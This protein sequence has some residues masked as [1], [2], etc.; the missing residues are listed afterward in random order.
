[1]P[2]RD[3]TLRLQDILEA[4]SR[5]Q[6]Y[7]AGHTLQAFSGDDMVV[8]AVVRNLEVIGE[9]V[10]HVDDATMVRLPG[11]PWRDMRDLRNLLVHEYFGVSVT[12]WETVIRDVPPV[13]LA[14]QAH[15]GR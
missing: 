12:I 3:S 10:R 1:M 8:D 5:I 9:A 2:P 7:T 6:R 13:A 4:L 11:V 14:I 15:L